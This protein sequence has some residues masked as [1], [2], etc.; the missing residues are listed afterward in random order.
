[1]EAKNLLFRTKKTFNLR[2]RL[3]TLE[4]PVVMGI[5]NSTPD[6]FYANSR[7]SSTDAAL[8]R[9]ERMLADGATILDIGGYS[10]RP[11]AA[12]VEEQEEADR[13]APVI[14]AIVK[15]FPEAIVSVDTFR[16]SVAE[17]AVR[18]GAVMVNDVSGG[19]DERMFETVSRLDVPY[20]LMHS[21]GTPQTM[22]QLTQ[23]TDMLSEM[24]TFFITRLHMIR[25]SGIKDVILDVGF[26]FAKT[27]EQNYF[28]L[29]NLE[30]FHILE[31][32]M[33]V[34]IS[35]KSMIY[36]RLNITPEESLNGTTVLNTLALSKGAQLLRVHDVKEAVDSVKLYNLMASS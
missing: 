11:G 23:Y 9:A 33:L 1:M 12:E 2:G 20:I 27:I 32:P 36:K 13:V 34:G 30:H 6:S 22:T 14:E 24:L 31:L 25:K 35:R 16:A 5:I 19:A 21:K 28:L 3:W 8:H 17:T 29:K 15:H 18:A 10:T 26:G 4:Q 7:M